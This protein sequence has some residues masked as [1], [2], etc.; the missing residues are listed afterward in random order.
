[1]C[2]VVYGEQEPFAD[3]YLYK[4]VVQLNGC[5]YSPLYP[6]KWELNKKLVSNATPKKYNRYDAVFRGI[7]LFDFCVVD[8]I[9]NILKHYHK[10]NLCLLKCKVQPEDFIACGTWYHISSNYVYIAATPVS[11]ESVNNENCETQ[12]I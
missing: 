4:F 12:K 8:K 11:I 10:N 2:L 3:K 7:H 9:F 5:L 6:I 1:M